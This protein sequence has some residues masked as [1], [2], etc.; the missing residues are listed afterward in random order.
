MYKE[1][2]ENLHLTKA[3]TAHD[4]ET[5]RDSESGHLREIDP[6][7]CPFSLM[8]CCHETGKW[9]I[10]EGA[11]TIISIIM[12]KIR[13]N[14]SHQHGQALK[15]IGVIGAIRKGKSYFLNRVAGRQSGFG[16]GDDATLTCTEGIWVWF[17]P[18]SNIILLD[19]AG[20]T[21]I[22]MSI[23]FCDVLNF[24]F[25]FQVCLTAAVEIKSLMNSYFCALLF[26]PPW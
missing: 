21:A 25:L 9:S 18:E 14:P 23:C 2:V 7:V 10:A 26:F 24:L 8:S 16:V 1:V 11:E 12:E 3:R 17:L 20:I 15:V 22:Y 13:N 6:S 5:P 19:T 4:P